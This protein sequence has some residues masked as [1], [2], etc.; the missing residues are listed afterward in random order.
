[1]ATQDDYDRIQERI[2]V[3]E[4]SEEDYN[5][6]EAQIKVAKKHA[7]DARACFARARELLNSK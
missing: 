5:R 3:T 2:K 6:L 1:M 4:I 7:E